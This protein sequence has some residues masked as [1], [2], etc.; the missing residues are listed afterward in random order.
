MLSGQF[1]RLNIPRRMLIWT[2]LGSQIA[3]EVRIKEPLQFLTTIPG[4]RTRTGTGLQYDELS[5]TRPGEE[6][7]FIQQRVILPPRDHLTLQRALLKNSYLIVAEFDDDPRHFAEMVKHGFPGAPELPLRAN[8]DRDPGRNITGLQ[9][10]RGR[11]S[12][13]GSSIGNTRYSSYRRPS[14][15]LADAFFRS[16]EPRG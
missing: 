7:I 15:P 1:V 9:S 6:K 16:P 13:S 14:T 10:Q 3:S 2:L 4:V 5:R 11:L 8:D 12:Q